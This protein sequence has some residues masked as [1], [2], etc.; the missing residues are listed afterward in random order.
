MYGCS[1]GGDV[2]KVRDHCHISGS[3]RFALCSQCNLTRVKCLFEV[4]VF[5]NG[6]CNYDSHFIVRQ[7][8]NHPLWRIHIVPRNSEKYLA[9]TYRSLHFKDSCQFLGESL[10]TLVQNLKMKGVD[11]FRYLNRFIQNEEER[12]LMS[13]KGV[14]PYSYVTHPDVLLQTTLPDKDKFFNNIFLM[15]AMLLLRKSGKFSDVRI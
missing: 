7:L 1:F 12:E 6:L 2:L 10:A 4:P 11:M 14:F 5:F 3:Y 15:N 13:S 8:V 9:F